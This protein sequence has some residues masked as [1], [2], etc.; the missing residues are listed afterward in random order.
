MKQRNLEIT[1]AIFK[2][3]GIIVKKGIISDLFLYFLLDFDVGK[4]I[5]KD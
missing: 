5:I 1:I 4:L 2:L 3:V